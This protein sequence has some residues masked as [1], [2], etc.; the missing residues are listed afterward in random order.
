[1]FFVDDS[2]WVA[3]SVKPGEKRYGKGE[4]LGLPDGRR[5]RVVATSTLM[6]RVRPL[7][8]WERLWLWILLRVR[9]S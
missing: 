5:V 8:L 2:F 6:L 3:A 1:M 7:R 4:W 9:R